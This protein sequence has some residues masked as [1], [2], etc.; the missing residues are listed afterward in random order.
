MKE[1]S[2][3]QRK[4]RGQEKPA[5]HSLSL[6]LTEKCHIDYLSGYFVNTR[7]RTDFAVCPNIGK[8]QKTQ[9]MT[10]DAVLVYGLSSAAINKY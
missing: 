1:R 8:I 5:F 7:S 10:G 4:E 6:F 3:D 9:Q 2:N